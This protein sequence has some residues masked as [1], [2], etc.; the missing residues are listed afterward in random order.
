MNTMT[1][2]AEFKANTVKGATNNDVMRS[3]RGGIWSTGWTWT[4]MSKTTGMV[5]VKRSRAGDDMV[6]LF[7]L[8]K[9][10]KKSVQVQKKVTRGK[11]KGKNI[12]TMTVL[13]KPHWIA[14]YI[15]VPKSMIKSAHQGK[16]TFR[17][18]VGM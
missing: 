1:F 10:N 16:R 6:R 14:T 18:I 2:P 5:L 15:D 17:L 11:N 12:S 7:R 3:L 9:F 13:R 8:Q 4:S